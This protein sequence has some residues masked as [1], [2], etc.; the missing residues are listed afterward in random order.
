MS[1]PRLRFRCACLRRAAAIGA[2][3]PYRLRRIIG[4][5]RSPGLGRAGSRADRR[6]RLDR[7]KDRARG[8][9]RQHTA[10]AAILAALKAAASPMP[11][12]RPRGCRCIRRAR[13]SRPNGPMRITGYRASNRVTL[14]VRD[15]TK[16]AGTIDALVAAGAN[17]IGGIDF[18]CRRNRRRWTRRGQAL[19]DARRKAEIYAQ[20]ATSA[21]ARRSASARKARRR[22]QPCR[23][24]AR[25][26][27]AAPPRRSRPARRRCGCR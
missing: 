17:E 4:H 1:S 16:V 25:I 6:R 10:M 18:W 3:G 24:A 8:E 23:C 9:R 26:Q 12:S 11:T 13:R 22:R 20:A 27:G 5:R 19:D 14:R 21:S 7:S 15:V 2:Q